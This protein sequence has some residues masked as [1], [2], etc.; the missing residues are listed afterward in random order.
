MKL[1][2]IAYNV[3]PASGDETVIEIFDAI[4]SE[5]STSFWTGEKGTEVTPKDFEAKL[6]AV[7]TPN[8]TIRMNSG[9]GEVTAANVIAVAI[10]EARKAGKNIVC[11]VVGMC[12][13]AAVQIAISCEKVLIHESALMMIHDPKCFMYGFCGIA[14]LNETGSMLTATKNGI[15]NYYEKK[16]GKSRDELSS[17]MSV[18]TWMDGREAVENGF[19]DA[20]MFE[21]DVPST[22]V[23]N[24]INRVFNSCTFATI[25]EK[26]RG[27]ATNNINNEGGVTEMEIKTVADLTAKYPELVNQ[28]KENAVNEAHTAAVNSGVEQERSRLKAIDEL[29]GKVSDDLLNKAKYETFDTAEKVAVEAL[30]TGAFN[31]TAVINGMKQESAAANNVGGAATN[32]VG[33][34]PVTNDKKTATDH[35]KNVAAAY[36]QKTGKGGNK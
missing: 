8:V 25:P 19:A 34:T 6:N 31:N 15:I 3:L 24:S 36:F 32:G 2:K 10:Q 21:D 14:D 33:A 28:V 5:Q 12:A 1:T 27:I 29:A 13:S 16:T 18:T 30:K 26:Y 4:A 22:E 11:K 7:T 35:A 17:M 9:G 20:L 23:A